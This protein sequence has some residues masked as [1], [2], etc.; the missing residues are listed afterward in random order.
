MGALGS[1]IER[2]RVRE[3]ARERAGRE[4]S[5]LRGQRRLQAIWSR[6][7][8]GIEGIEGVDKAGE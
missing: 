7:S 5:V 3:A 6:E 4:A 1:E 8:L 2:E